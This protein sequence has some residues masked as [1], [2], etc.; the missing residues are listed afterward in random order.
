MSVFANFVFDNERLALELATNRGWADFIRW[1][2]SAGSPALRR[3]ADDGTCRE[4][5]RLY[6]EIGRAAKAKRPGDSARAVANR[7]LEI[8][9]VEGRFAVGQEPD[10]SE[11]AG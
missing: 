9:I 4:P 7:L 5:A 1:A 11:D 2:R 3:L 8:G 10:D 6:D